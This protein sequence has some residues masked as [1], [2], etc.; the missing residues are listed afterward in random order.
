[1][2][3]VNKKYA[4]LHTGAPHT[5]LLFADGQAAPGNQPANLPGKPEDQSILT[6]PYDVL[7]TTSDRGL[8]QLPTLPAISVE[9]LPCILL[10]GEKLLSSIFRLP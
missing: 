6:E 9:V 3:S 7:M 5:L 2:K 10:S 8:A 1:M 4:A